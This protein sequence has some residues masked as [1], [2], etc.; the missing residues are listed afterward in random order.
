MK[1]T[2]LLLAILGATGM[3]KLRAQGCVTCTQTAANLG[4]SSAHGLNN[5]IIYLACLPLL[6]IGIVTYIWIKRNKA[7]N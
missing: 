6:F 4:E 5:G 3:G 1:K 7:T 2:R